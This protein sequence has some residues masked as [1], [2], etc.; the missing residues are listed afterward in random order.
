MAT[1]RHCATGTHSFRAAPNGRTFC[2]KCPLVPCKAGECDISLHPVPT[3]HFPP[4][5]DAI[6]RKC[7]ERTTWSPMKGARMSDPH[8]LAHDHDETA[9]RHGHAPRDIAKEDATLVKSL[10]DETSRNAKRKPTPKAPPAPP[11]PKTVPV[12]PSAKAAARAAIAKGTRK[13]S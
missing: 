10:L 6:C 9:R 13:G 12:T 7:G 11:L 4:E 1:V 5:F 8:V 2:A 3:K